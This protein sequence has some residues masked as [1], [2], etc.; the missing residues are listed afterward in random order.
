MYAYVT[1]LHCCSPL[2]LLFLQHPRAPDARNTQTWALD[3]GD[4]S[5]QPPI[6]GEI[7]SS[8]LEARLPSSAV[9]VSRESALGG[10]WG[11]GVSQAC[12]PALRLTASRPASAGAAWYPR[13]I[14]VGEV[15]GG[16]E[17]GEGGGGGEGWGG[18]GG[19]LICCLPLSFD[20]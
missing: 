20:L 2:T 18:R 12:G 16:C 19:L 10:G 17:V 9:V 1:P 13:Q 15:S 7:S 6:S 14:T 11:Y 8:S 5:L 3:T 4:P